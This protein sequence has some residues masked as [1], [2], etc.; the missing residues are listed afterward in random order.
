MP[1]WGGSQS[2]VT[3]NPRSFFFSQP[4]SPRNGKIKKRN[5]HCYPFSSLLHIQFVES[6]VEVF[7]LHLP[8][9][10]LVLSLPAIIKVPHDLL[11]ILFFLDNTMQ[12]GFFKL[13]HTMSLAW[14]RP[15]LWYSIAF[16]FSS[17][18]M[19]L[20]FLGVEAVALSLKAL[21]DKG[22]VG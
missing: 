3:R 7:M 22:K 15:H 4:L 16:N 18:D 17:I 14:L 9:S 1:S 8:L 10:M 21:V 2:Y 13:Y 5:V 11:H 6:S 19:V 12:V 20:S